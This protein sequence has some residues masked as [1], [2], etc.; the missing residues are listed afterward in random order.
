MKEVLKTSLRA[1]VPDVERTSVYLIDLIVHNNL[2]F[3][4]QVT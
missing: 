1:P 2:A 3:S 4:L